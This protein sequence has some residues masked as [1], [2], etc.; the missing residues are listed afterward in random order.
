ML[1]KGKRLINSPLPH[2]FMLFFLFTSFCAVPN[3][4]NIWKRLPGGT[5]IWKGRGYSSEIL[6]LTPKGDQSGC[7]PTFCHL[8]ETFLNFDYMN[9]VNI[10]N[11]KYIFLYFLTYNPKRPLR[12]NILAFC[13]EHPKWDQNPKFLPLI[14]AT[15]IPAPFIWESPV[16]ATLVSVPWHEDFRA[17]WGK[18]EKCGGV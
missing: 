6:N 4:L 12:L 13:P 3:N 9:R 1:Y 11:W 16:E 7:G 18:L 8:Q 14:E 5:P 15:S 17:N 10:A 2:P